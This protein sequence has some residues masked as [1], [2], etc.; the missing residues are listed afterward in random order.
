VLDAVSD[1]RFFR[2]HVYVHGALRMVVTMLD[3]VLIGVMLLSALLA[4]VRGVT[5]EVLSIASWLAA[6]LAALF[7]YK[8][9][10]PVLEPHV[11]S[12][13]LSQVIAAGGVFLITLI[14]VSY[15]TARISD[16]VLDSNIGVLDRTLGFVFGAARGLLLVVIAF[17]FFT[18]FV[19]DETKQPDWVKNAKSKP[20]LEVTA[21]QVLAFLP[22]DPAAAV[23][24]IKQNAPA[25]ATGAGAGSPSAP[26][27][28]PRP[29]SPQP[30]TGYDKNERRELKQLLEQ[31]TPVQN[32]PTR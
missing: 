27:S 20:L 2:E 24:Q 28:A 1:S 6:A 30:Q 12:E 14:L 25:A 17:M 9:I 11:H 22:A 31:G 4:M 8:K 32:A 19:P 23:D 10:A 3:L 13:F 7:L 18:W 29:A 15:I 16:F 5:R 21:E 26:A